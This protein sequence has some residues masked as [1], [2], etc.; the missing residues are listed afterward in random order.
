[1]EADAPDEDHLIA[2]GEI[3]PLG[4]VDIAPPRVLP[5]ACEL[6]DLCVL[7][8]GLRQL[9]AMLLN[10]LHDT[11]GG[12]Q[13]GCDLAHC[14][15]YGGKVRQCQPHGIL[16]LACDESARKDAWREDEDNR[17]RTQ[18][19]LWDI[20][21]QDA[22]CHACGPVWA[23]DEDGNLAEVQPRAVQDHLYG[24]GRHG[25][26]SN[27]LLD[28]DFLAE[29]KANAILPQACEEL[30]EETHRYSDDNARDESII[31]QIPARL[32]CNDDA[33][34]DVHRNARN[35]W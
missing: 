16:P 18:K 29:E 19:H 2:Q 33:R 17:H 22:T 34:E 31:P 32:V 27:E 8:S 10:G 21:L 26:N 15:S 11:E 20:E 6:P 1:M 13:A 5:L 28:F 3:A 9:V 4:D 35:G 12:C 24:L 25:I 7:R 23:T 14:G 30:V